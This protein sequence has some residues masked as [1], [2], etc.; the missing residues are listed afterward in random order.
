[1]GISECDNRSETVRSPPV[2]YFQRNSNSVSS[3]TSS[4][5]S[6]GHDSLE[7]T[8]T[9]NL[10]SIPEAQV[11]LSSEGTPEEH[12]SPLRSP[13][14]RNS[15]FRSLKRSYLIPRAG[16]LSNGVQADTIGYIS[17]VEQVV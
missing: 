11:W 14:S 4:T 17:E 7:S 10:K 16:S 8:K 2:I 12:R 13:S 15:S 9:L 1:M 6:S 3:T 5:S